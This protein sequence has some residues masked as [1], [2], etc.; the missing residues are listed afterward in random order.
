[1][2]D[3]DATKSWSDATSARDTDAGAATSGIL[4][5]PQRQLG[6]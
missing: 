3:E 6:L 2:L 5:M 1:M 4:H